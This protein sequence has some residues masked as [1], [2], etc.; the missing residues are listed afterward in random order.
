MLP[1]RPVLPRRLRVWRRHARPRRWRRWPP[2]RV[3]AGLATIALTT[4]AAAPA[5]QSPAPS[6]P[7]HQP[8]VVAPVVDTFR[9]P[10]H[11]YG[12]GNRG[13]EY[14]TESGTVVEASADGQVVFAGPVA[15]SRHVTLLHPGGIRTSY[16]Y[17]DRVDVV[18]GQQVRQGQRLGLAGERLHFGARLGD[19]YID[20]ATLFGTMV[21]EVELLPFEVPPGRRGEPVTERLRTLERDV[22]YDPPPVDVAVRFGQRAALLGYRSVQ[23]S[24]A[25]RGT[26]VAWDVAGRLARPQP[27]TSQAPPPRPAATRGERV[28]LLVGGLGSSSRS[29]SID[30]LRA[31]ELGYAADAVVRFSYRGGRTPGTGS[32]FASLAPRPYV[33]AD[34][35]GDLRRSATRL[36][37]AIE[38]VAAERPHAT[39]DLFAHS[40]GGVVTRLAL[41]ELERRG[42][43]LGQLGLVATLGSPHGGADLATVL[44]AAGATAGGRAAR[45][46]TGALLD[47]GLDPE[48]PAV[49]QLAETSDVVAEIQAAG[50]PDGVD[51]VSIAASGDYVVTVPNTVAEG[52]RNVTVGLVGRR[53]HGDLVASDAATR[54]LALALAGLPPACESALTTVGEELLGHGISYTEDVA[55]AGLAGLPG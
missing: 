14:D 35:Q 31:G 12:P 22:F 42:A 29:A 53:A 27:C 40:M 18:V 51:L 25:V 7:R 23:L 39:V 30:Q 16:S 32:G 15:S 8:P 5:H 50:L 48:S 28:A 52:A 46:A 3:L 10:R 13:I 37:D 47:T 20:P 41:L 9:P 49:R 54:E 55:G 44:A 26:A 24:P 17:L 45:D 21:T 6:S 2:A 34:T 33:S 19:A 38:A 11:P 43:D 4:G 1:V 36:A